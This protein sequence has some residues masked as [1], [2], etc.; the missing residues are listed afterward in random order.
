MKMVINQRE[1]VKKHNNVITTPYINTLIMVLYFSRAA[2]AHRAQRQRA[3]PAAG[4]HSWCA[5]DPPR[6]PRA[7]GGSGQGGQSA[8]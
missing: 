2:T 7:R 3:Q 4:T 1:T 5:I 6:P 8:W